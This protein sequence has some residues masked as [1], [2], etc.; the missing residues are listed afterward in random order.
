METIN[1]DKIFP[2]TLMH[3]YY[4]TGYIF[5]PDN[6][7]EDKLGYFKRENSE[8]IFLG[9]TTIYK[10]EDD[11]LKIFN[12]TDSTWK[13]T[14]IE[15]ISSDTL[16]LIT[17]DS[18]LIKY[19]KANYE[20]NNELSFDK[21]IVSTLGIGST[22]DVSIDKKGIVTCSGG[23]NT[24]S[25]LFSAKVDEQVFSK[26][27]LNFKK[28]N[29]EQLN[30]DY[31]LN[32]NDCRM[33]WVTFIKD[34]K[35]YK[36]IKDYGNQAPLEFYWAYMPV[37]F[38]YQTIK[39]K[40]LTKGQFNQL[41]SSHIILET[42]RKVCLLEKSEFFYFIT[43]LYNSKQVK[44]NFK[45]KYDLIYWNK[46][47]KE[48]R[49]KTDGRFYSIEKNGITTTVDLGYNFIERNNLIKKFRTKTEND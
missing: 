33:I 31:S 25:S 36:T 15:S 10:I 48:K 11:S 24:D 22:N 14:K 4:K 21:I 28:A 46:D 42:K 12:L 34:N 27:E 40:P 41:S 6:S 30:D 17:K 13:N 9:T 5:Y 18:S 1:P 47:Y 8:W 37:R 2:P 7:C 16:T 20:I 19:A 38:L 35:I 39:L 3:S 32:C 49:I 26:I 23:Y 44:L 43:E 29:V 45:S